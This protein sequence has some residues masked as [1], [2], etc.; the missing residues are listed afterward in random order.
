MATTIAL[1]GSV[2]HSSA[3]LSCKGV[4]TALTPERKATY[5]TL[6]AHSLDAKVAASKVEIHT[7]MEAASWSVVYADVPIA[8][9]GYFFFK[10][11]D[12]KPRF[13]EVWGGMADESETPELVRWAEK[14]GTPR[15]VAECFAKAAVSE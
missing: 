15:S 10:I 12:G 13:E 6:V 5:S 11:V 1:L 3:N 14:L 2:S 9:P 7:F 8:D 4:D